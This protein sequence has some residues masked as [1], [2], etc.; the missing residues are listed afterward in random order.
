MRC[1]PTST[2]SRLVTSVLKGC[3]L[4]TAGT[5]GH[6]EKK[7]AA[8]RVSAS[9]DPRPD[10]AAEEIKRVPG[11]RRKGCLKRI[12]GD[13]NHCR[14]SSRGAANAPSRVST[15]SAGSTRPALHAQVTGGRPPFGF[16]EIGG[17]RGSTLNHKASGKKRVWHS[18]SWL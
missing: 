17:A 12:V 10:Q 5:A 3:F 18:L 7:Y 13:E 8:A 11:D 4:L 2:R 14:G 15:A 1:P 9:L 16:A 6:V